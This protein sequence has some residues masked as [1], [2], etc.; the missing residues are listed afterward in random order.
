ML[1]SANILTVVEAIHDKC[2][3]ATNVD[4]V[5]PT[6]TRFTDKADYWA[7]VDSTN[8]TLLEIET[9]LIRAVWISYLR[10]TDDDRFLDSPVK[11]IAY[12]I[13]LFTESTFERL[14]EP[15]AAD[16]FEAK[17]SLTDHQHDTSLFSLQTQFQGINPLGLSSVTF[18]VSETVSLA[19]IDN[20]QRLV[21][22]P[23]ILDNSVIGSLSKFECLANIQLAC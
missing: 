4:T 2:A 22:C 15:V 20:T 18:T 21:P 11:Q 3:L 1:S 8:D 17:V 5:F 7:F 23:F 6:A 10:F 14:D 9:E 12:E 16:A 13:T 19:Q